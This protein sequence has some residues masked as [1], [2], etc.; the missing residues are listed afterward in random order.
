M[1][2]LPLYLELII[3]AFASARISVLIVRDTILSKPR[4][5][6]FRRYPPIDDPYSGY[7]YQQRDKTGRNL[8]K[9]IIRDATFLG[10]LLS[11]TN[12]ISVWV[13]LIVS[14]SY[15]NGNNIVKQGITVIAVMGLSSILAKK[16]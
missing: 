10:N 15:L 14:I 12:C 4:D 1:S 5:W 9:S 8:P 11:C 7:S 3:I 13:T 2:N 16:I 6:I